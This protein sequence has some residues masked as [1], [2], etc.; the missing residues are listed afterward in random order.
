MFVFLTKSFWL[1][2]FTEKCWKSRLIRRPR[3]F[4]QYK[5]LILGPR[6]FNLFDIRIALTKNSLLRENSFLF[7][8]RCCSMSFPANQIR[9]SNSSDFYFFNLKSYILDPIPKSIPCATYLI[10]DLFS[11][12]L[13]KFPKLH[14]KCFWVLLSWA[15]KRPTFPLGETKKSSLS[16]I[17]FAWG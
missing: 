9:Q 5:V 8:C 4:F 7:R 12:M 14:F 1:G 11:R 10:T 15:T 13:W 3:T 17:T 2:I 6:L 16:S